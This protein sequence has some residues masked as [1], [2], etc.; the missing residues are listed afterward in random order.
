MISQREVATGCGSG[1]NDGNGDGGQHNEGRWLVE[2]TLSTNLCTQYGCGAYNTG[3]S[4]AS[5]SGAA[6]CNEIDNPFWTPN[7]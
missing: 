3:G 7:L 1:K 5:G 4:G 2:I 6:I